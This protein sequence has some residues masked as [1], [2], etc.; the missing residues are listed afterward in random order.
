[1]LTW[2]EKEKEKK[3]EKDLWNNNIRRDFAL[4]DE[5][6]LWPPVLLVRPA[7]A[8]AAVV[9]G[10]QD[11]R[12][13]GRLALRHFRRAGKTNISMSALYML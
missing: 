4:F 5:F 11:D 8:L 13:E 2:M 6:P 9:D 7:Q 3:K 12:D 1:M 10:G